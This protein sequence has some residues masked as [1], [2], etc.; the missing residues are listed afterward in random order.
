MCINK[1][2]LS[3][4]VWLYNTVLYILEEGL[5][6]EEK[7]KGPG[8]WF[9]LECRTNHLTAM[10]IW[11]KVF[12]RTSLM[13][14][15]WFGMVWTGLSSIFPK[16]PFHQVAASLFIL[17][18]KSSWWKI[19]SAARNWI[20]SVP[21]NSSDNLYLLFCIYPSSMSNI[22]ETS[23]LMCDISERRRPRRRWLT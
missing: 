10:I 4:W 3:L 17:F 18:F 7:A 12:R 23:W 19:A 20:H 6:T 1:S 14:G 8:C 16:H 9:I 11:T 22:I 5:N 15:C 21:P 2:P 13:V